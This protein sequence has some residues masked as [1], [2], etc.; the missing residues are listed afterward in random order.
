MFSY[1]Y[2]GFADEIHPA[3][4]KQMDAFESLGIRFIELR[5]L[6]GKNI[7]EL[8]KE[9]AI[10]IK[11]AFDK[12]GFGVSAIGSPVGKTEITAPNDVEVAKLKHIIELANI[13]ETKM[14]RIF[15]PYI[16]ENEPAKKYRDIVL[17]RVQEYTDVVKGTDILLLHENEGG[18]IYGQAPENCLDIVESIGS[19]N[20]KVIYD[21]GNFAYA[22]FDAWEA[23]K[24]LEN[25]IEHVHIK[26][27]QGNETVV[28]AGEGKV[29][30]PQIL[31][32]LKEK[33]RHYYFVHEPHLADFAGL[34]SFDKNSFEKRQGDPYD[35]FRMAY[36]KFDRIVKESLID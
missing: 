7:S 18:Y 20:L 12:R 26:D 15:S 5:G 9:E 14:I 11:K 36:E 32:A 2:S 3:T 21:P 31:R 28:P 19:P 29:Q 33:E 1:T 30:Y 10:E 6:S 4:D 35:L 34:S 22:G 16:P 8:T 25:Y 13:F 23:Y 17:R 24:L 27:S